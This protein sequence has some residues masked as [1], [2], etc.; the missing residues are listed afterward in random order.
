MHPK[1]VQ[2]YLLCGT[3]TGARRHIVDTVDDRKI[4]VLFNKRELQLF[5]RDQMGRKVPNE[6]IIGGDE[7]D[8]V[9]SDLLIVD[10]SKQSDPVTR[11]QTMILM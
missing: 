10:D 1:I 9:L 8:I 5:F 2:Y 4:K 7:D 6:N 3:R 11:E